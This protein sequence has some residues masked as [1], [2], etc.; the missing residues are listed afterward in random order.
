[1]RSLACVFET[2]RPSEKANSPRAKPSSN[3]MRVSMQGV[4]GQ[5]VRNPLLPRLRGTQVKWKN[6]GQLCLL[7]SARQ[8][9]VV[10]HC[11]PAFWATS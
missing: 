9:V 4:V 5:R 10:L 7:F 1:M 6:V 3:E 2:T 8:I 11:K